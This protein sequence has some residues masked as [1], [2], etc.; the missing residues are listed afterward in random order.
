MGSEMCIRDRTLI[1]PSWWTL[2][3]TVPFWLF[4]I[5]A[6]DVS[7]S[8]TH[9]QRDDQI[10]DLNDGNQLVP[11]ITRF[12]WPDER[13]TTP[14]QVKLRATLYEAISCFTL[15]PA[16]A[17]TAFVS[18]GGF[19]YLLAMLF[20]LPAFG[21]IISSF[22]PFGGARVMFAEFFAGVSIASILALVIG[23]G[24]V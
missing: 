22:L 15:V 14:L 24:N 5:L 3:A 16:I 21:Y 7:I 2:A 1:A 23:L 4:Q 11:S 20:P 12:F 10:K 13:V 19:L 9:G 6:N 8:G 17:L 18:G